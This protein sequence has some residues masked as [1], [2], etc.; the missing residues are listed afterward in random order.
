MCDILD[1]FVFASSFQ[2]SNSKLNSKCTNT[3][4]YKYVYTAIYIFIYVYTILSA[5]TFGGNPMSK[6]VVEQ[7]SIENPVNCQIFTIFPLICV[8]VWPHVYA[9]SYKWEEK[10]ISRLHAITR[11]RLKLQRDFACTNW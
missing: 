2:R 10:I 8:Y 7:L 5:P 11:T 4:V 6:F 3:D 1:E 9:Y